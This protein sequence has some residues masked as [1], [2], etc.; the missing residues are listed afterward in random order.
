M[1]RFIWYVLYGLC[2][3][4]LSTMFSAVLTIQLVPPSGQQGELCLF[5]KKSCCSGCDGSLQ[6]LFTDCSAILIQHQDDAC[7]MLG[8]FTPSTIN[9][10]S[11]LLLFMVCVGQQQ[12]VNYNNLWP[13]LCLRASHS[14]VQDCGPGSGSVLGVGGEGDR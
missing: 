9:P 3:S 2:L 6:I 14:T 7:K 5:F 11:S 8:V 10:Q 4:V 1:L 12:S 13:C